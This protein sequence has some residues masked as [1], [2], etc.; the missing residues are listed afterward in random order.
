MQPAPAPHHLAALQRDSLERRKTT[1][2]GRWEGEQ[3]GAQLEERTEGHNH[4]PLWPR[5]Q[6]KLVPA[7]GPR[8]LAGLK[9][10]LGSWL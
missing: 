7:H 2:G 8:W 3:E 1:G 5:Q 6:L 9:A 10:G 4:P